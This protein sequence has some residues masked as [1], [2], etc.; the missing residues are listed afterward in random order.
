LR[1]NAHSTPP[2]TS[3]SIRF[4]HEPYARYLGNCR[5]LRWI[6]RRPPFGTNPIFSRISL[7]PGHPF[8]VGHGFPAPLAQPV[9]HPLLIFHTFCGAPGSPAGP[10]WGTTARSTG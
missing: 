3:G 7:L 1:L 6:G 4:S 9:P 10:D 2:Q 5:R 8:G